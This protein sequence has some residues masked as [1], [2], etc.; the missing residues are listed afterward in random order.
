[1][2]MAIELSEAVLAMIQIATCSLIST[3]HFRKIC[4]R[5]KRSP[6]TKFSGVHKTPES[7][8]GS[9]DPGTF[10]GTRYEG[11]HDPAQNIRDDLDEQLTNINLMSGDGQHEIKY[12]WD[13]VTDRL[14]AKI[15]MGA[16]E[17]H[18]RYE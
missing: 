13:I 8:I 4:H 16:N 18:A 1:M 15:L 6:R 14:W 5:T 17:Y 11:L 7:I 12:I 9:F 3:D 10:A 2:E